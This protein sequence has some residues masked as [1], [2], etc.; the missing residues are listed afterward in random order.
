MIH[1]IKNWIYR[2]RVLFKRNALEYIIFFSC[3]CAA[4]IDAYNFPARKAFTYLNVVLT[5]AAVA[6]SLREK[7]KS[8]QII[9]LS[10]VSKLSAKSFIFQYLPLGS[11]DYC[12]FK[13]CETYQY[14]IPIIIQ[15]SPLE[16][17][18]ENLKR[19]TILEFNFNFLPLN[20]ASSKIYVS[21]IEIQAFSLNKTPLWTQAYKNDRSFVF[22]D[23][24]SNHPFSI[25]IFLY[26]TFGSAQ[27]F[28]FRYYFMWKRSYYK[29]KLSENT[30]ECLILFDQETHKPYLLSCES[31]PCK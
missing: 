17:H 24:L 31:F 2:A 6:I 20:L 9:Q 10:S 27:L 15:P 19:P 22:I 7:D 14:I 30:I 21:N 29:S 8:L 28:K 11:M 4:I 13:D 25:S 16:L 5:G 23:N 3:S 1:N 12:I 18:Q 26:G